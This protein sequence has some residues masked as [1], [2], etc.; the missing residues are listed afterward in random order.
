MR[1]TRYEYKK[2]G[3]MKFLCCIVVIVGISIVGGLYIS[4]FIFSGKQIPDNNDNSYSTEEKLTVENEK[5][6]ALQCGYF[7]NQE[8]AQVALSS[9]IGDFQPFLSEEDGKYRVI[10][11][12]Y[13]EEEAKQKI[14]ELKAKGIE[15]SKIDLNIPANSVENKKIIEVIDG[16]F[17][18]TNKLED[19][20]VQ[21]IKTSDY[22]IWANQIINEGKTST[23]NELDDLSKYVNDLPEEIDKSNSSINIQKLYQLIK[24]HKTSN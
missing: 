16:L 21:S 11:G 13:K 8:N 2:S 22:K 12:I 14:E 4:K 6:I 24:T 15:V 3:K 19:S 7:S 17:Q 23:S 10:A 5:I 20:E 18:I 9:V 1:Y